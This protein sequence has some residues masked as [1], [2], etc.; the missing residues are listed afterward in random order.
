[1]VESGDGTQISKSESNTYAV[2]KFVRH[3][4]QPAG[5]IHRITAALLVDDV[6]EAKE[7]NGKSTEVRR[8]RTPDELNQIAELAKAAIGVDL[9]RGD[10]SNGRESIV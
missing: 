7:E 3:V 2:N 8:K 1:M 5:R 9:T 10:T 6:V 4:L